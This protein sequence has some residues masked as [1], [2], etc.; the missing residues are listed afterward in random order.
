MLSEFMI[1]LLTL[2][3]TMVVCVACINQLCQ[4][5]QIFQAT[6]ARLESERWLLGQC[7]DPHFFSNMHMHTD[8][9]FTVENNARVGVFMLSLREFTQSLLASELVSRLAGGWVHRLIFSWPAAFFGVLFL[10]FGPSWL[11]CGSRA[12]MPR[13]WPDCREGHFKDA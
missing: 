9:C 10:F 2:S 5:Y 6:S 7:E 3:C 11:V 1:P 12:M 13:R 8:I 4:F